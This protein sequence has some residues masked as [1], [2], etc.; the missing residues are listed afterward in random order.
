MEDLPEHGVLGREAILRCLAATPPLVEGLIDPESQVQV[1]GIDLTL[2]S[3]MGFT[4]AGR[5]GAG[6]V[7]TVSQCAELPFEQD[8]WV[9]LPPGPYLL[10][11]NEVV[12]LPKHI[13]AFAYP[14][15]SLLRCGV[16]IHNAVWDAGYEGRSQSLV[17]VYNRCG[18]DVARNAR[19]LQMVFHYLSKPVAEGYNGA[20]QREN[21]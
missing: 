14:R 6:P 18:F 19:V 2:R 17:V 7:R 16:S 1:N 10:T 4:T 5:V 20:Y 21:V 8:E 9:H 11:Y 13:A 3:V 12:H 15:S